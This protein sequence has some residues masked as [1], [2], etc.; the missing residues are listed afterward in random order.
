MVLGD[1]KT[2]VPFQIESTTTSQETMLYTASKGL[3]E[4]H[5][6]YG[7]N[8]TKVPIMIEAK[9]VGLNSDPSVLA[10]QQT[11]I[12]CGSPHEEEKP[13]AN[14][15]KWKMVIKKEKNSLTANIVGDDQIDGIVGQKR[16]KTVEETKHEN[17]EG[18][19]KTR[20]QVQDPTCTTAEAGDQPCQAQ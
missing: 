7:N 13:L 16:Y 8:F 18:R 19:K 5:K 3:M 17:N 4:N 10:T 6:I 14:V 9:G 12:P 20:G 2:S 15:R 1:E 11:H